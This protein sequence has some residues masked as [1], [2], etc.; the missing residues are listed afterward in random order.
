ML[1]HRLRPGAIID[2]AVMKYLN[3]ADRLPKKGYAI[4]SA[5]TSRIVRRTNDRRNFSTIGR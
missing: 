3:R 4:G 5:S 2:E 1:S